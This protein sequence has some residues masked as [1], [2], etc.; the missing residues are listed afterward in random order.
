M[1]LMISAHNI[2]MPMTDEAVMM[3]M[4][5]MISNE[6]EKAKHLSIRSHTPKNK[7]F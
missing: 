7:V 6:K 2:M 1:V 5:M 3:M 4:M